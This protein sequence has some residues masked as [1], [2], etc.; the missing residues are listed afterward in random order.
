M[1]RRT[2]LKLC[3]DQ[4]NSIA[5]KFFAWIVKLFDERGF[6]PSNRFID[7]LSYICECRAGVEVHLDDPDVVIDTNH[8]ERAL[9][10]I[11]TGRK[12]G[13]LSWTALG[14]KWRRSTA[15]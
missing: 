6:L 10:F 7:V 1:T 5:K 3:Q 4:A 14:T 11:P 12:D 8:L 15:I 2:T 13:L 9:R